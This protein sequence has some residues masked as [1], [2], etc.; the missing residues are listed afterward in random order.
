MKA[1]HL[2]VV[3]MTG[4]GPEGDNVL[5]FVAK[6]WSRRRAMLLAKRTARRLGLNGP[7]GL[8]VPTSRDVESRWLH[9]PWGEASVFQ[10]V[11]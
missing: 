9:L 6:N 1:H 7:I 5:E 4:E 11:P 3:F 10:A 2:L 8:F